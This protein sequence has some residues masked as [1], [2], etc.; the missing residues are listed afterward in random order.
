MP[1][2]R[3]RLSDVLIQLRISRSFELHVE[4]LQRGAFVISA[5]TFS[6][7]SVEHVTE[8]ACRSSIQNKCTDRC[9]FSHRGTK[10]FHD[11][12]F[13]EAKM[14]PPGPKLREYLG[15]FFHDSSKKLN[16]FDESRR[17]IPFVFFFANVSHIPFLICPEAIFLFL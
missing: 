8:M 15:V 12:I 11:E 9:E 13:D 4:L 14:N 3:L 7:F 16:L 2:T 1:C 17:K 5:I 6:P 10:L